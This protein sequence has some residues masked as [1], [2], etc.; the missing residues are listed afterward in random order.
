MMTTDENFS[1]S[2]EE[3]YTPACVTPESNSMTPVL[4]FDILKERFMTTALQAKSDL[5]DAL[6][7]ES[8]DDFVWLQK[9]DL[10]DIRL[11]GEADLK[12]KSFSPHHLDLG[13]SKDSPGLD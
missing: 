9:E 8:T 11:D 3:V 13:I 7:C 12:F 2:E 6:G 10:A 5:F 4:A 1:L